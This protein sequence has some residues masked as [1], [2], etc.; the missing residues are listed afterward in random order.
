MS[1]T[2]ALVVKEGVEGGPS[3]L[4]TVPGTVYVSDQRASSQG[5]GGG[6]TLFTHHS[7]RYST[8]MSVT[9]KKCFGIAPAP[10]PPLRQIKSK[11]AGQSR[12][13]ILASF[14]TEKV[15]KLKN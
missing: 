12:G 3:S 11:T 14:F 2:S 5:G 10:S 15:E 9:M 6:R 1:V 7:T 8:Y 4:T 13:R